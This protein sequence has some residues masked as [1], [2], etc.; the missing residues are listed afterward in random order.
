MQWKNVGRMYVA[1]T[2][3]NIITLWLLITTYWRPNGQI[4]TVSIS[5]RIH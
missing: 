5:K 1:A 4:K 2:K 3:A